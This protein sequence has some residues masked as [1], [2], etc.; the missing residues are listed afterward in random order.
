MQAD[1]FWLQCKSLRYIGIIIQF[2]CSHMGTLHFLKS[3]AI[4]LLPKYAQ[5]FCEYI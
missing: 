2:N 3:W 5:N 1:M 4:S